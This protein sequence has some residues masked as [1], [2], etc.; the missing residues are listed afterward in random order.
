MTNDEEQTATGALTFKTTYVRT[1][2][3]EES[4][5]GDDEAEDD[6]EGDDEAGGGQDTDGEDAPLP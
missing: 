3:T 6:E 1:A 2:P 4:D 5:P